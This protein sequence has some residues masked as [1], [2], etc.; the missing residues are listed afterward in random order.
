MLTGGQHQAR[1]RCGARAGSG[2]CRRVGL[3]GAGG[4]GSHFGA[5]RGRE[6]ESGRWERGVGPGRYGVPRLT[7]GFSPVAQEQ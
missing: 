1:A 4:L 5:G 3:G 2:H 6:W 7:V